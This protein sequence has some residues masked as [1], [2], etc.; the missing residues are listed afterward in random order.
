MAKALPEEF[1]PAERSYSLYEGIEYQGFWDDPRLRRQDV[2]ERHIISSMLPDS[3]RRILDLGGGYGRLA[4]SYVGRFDQAVLCDGSLSLLSDARATLG[5]RAI[6]V[7]ADLEQ[8]PFKPACFD[9]VLTIRVLQHVHDLPGTLGEIHRVLASD[10]RLVFSYHNKRNAKSM[11]GHFSAR[12]SANP[13]SLE[14]S[15]PM[16]TLISRHPTVVDRFLQ[17]TGFS[18]PDYQ[19]TAF[20]HPLANLTDKLGGPSPT[21]AWWAPFM[22][23]HRLAPWL[24]GRSF[25]HGGDRFHRELAIDDLF[26]C[27][28]CRGPLDRSGQGFQCPSCD[29]VYPV[30]DG[31]A[32]FR[33]P[34]SR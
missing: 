16:P 25:A 26:E 11:L 10:G 14:P 20:V 29:H 9:C 12:G 2:L 34:G 33:P 7:A 24:I 32:D 8:L 13:F 15:E 21:G 17:E 30:N 19:G 5:G 22:G 3:G 31:I 28:S 27:P 4:P 18:P 23:R 6:L 1:P